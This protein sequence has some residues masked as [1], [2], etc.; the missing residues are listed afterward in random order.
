MN[1]KPNIT[2]SYLSSQLKELEAD[3]IIKR[4]VYNET[5][6]RVEYSL[7]DIGRQFLDVMEICVIGDLI[8]LTTQLIFKSK[9]VG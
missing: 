4:T 2:H 5:P 1:L 6:L 9:F 7:T 8:T 3:L